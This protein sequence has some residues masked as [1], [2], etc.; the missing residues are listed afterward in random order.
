M[1]FYI[2]III[3]RKNYKLLVEQ[4]LKDNFKE[5]Y[6]ISSK[7]QTILLENNRPIFRNKGLKHRPPN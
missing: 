4:T 5:C 1:V 2:N 3:E 6:K 7:S